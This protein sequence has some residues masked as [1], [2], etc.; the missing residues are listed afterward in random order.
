MSKLC[1]KQCRRQVRLRGVKPSIL[2]TKKHTFKLHE[3]CQF[4][5]FI[6]GENN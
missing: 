5:Q 6:F 3:I 4:G 1:I 2:Q